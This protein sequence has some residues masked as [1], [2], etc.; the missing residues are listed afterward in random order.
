MKRPVL[1]V[2]SL[3]S[4]IG[5]FDLGLK[6]A[7]MSITW[8]VE[9]DNYAQKILTK[10]WPRVARYGDIRTIDWKKVEKVEL[11]C[12]GFPCQPF[13]CAGKQR[14]E[15]DDRY[16][17]PE[18]VRCLDALRP[19]WFLGENVP[20][21]I[22]MA[23]DQVCADLESL[24]Y[25]VWPV[26]IPAC[27]VDAPHQRERVWIVAHCDKQ[28]LQGGV[29]SRAASQERAPGGHLA[30]C[31]EDVADALREQSSGGLHGVERRQRSQSQATR[32]GRARHAVAN[33]GWT[34]EPN[35]GRVAHGIPARVDRLRGL[36]NAIIPQIA[37]TLGH[38]ILLTEQT[39]GH[40]TNGSK[41]K[42]DS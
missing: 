12:G 5:G 37:E 17:W 35:V 3:F 42:F 10:H 41:R 21:L 15:A 39:Y 31:G 11:V 6:R 27:A 28:G 40:R 19:A 14:G 9:N 13:S 36:G 25:T 20:G 22:K 26:C 1:T 38:A 29:G 18:V 30:E 4:G 2:G 23:L 16:L 33:V 7:G 32:N 24:G 34:V 8:Q